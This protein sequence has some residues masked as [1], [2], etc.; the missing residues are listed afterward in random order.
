M[1]A[2]GGFYLVGGRYGNVACCNGSDHYKLSTVSKHA[3]IEDLP[4]SRMH[5]L[6]LGI[7][8]DI[9]QP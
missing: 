3:V 8:I 4:C 9:P 7:A 6:P 2:A 5:H 1:S